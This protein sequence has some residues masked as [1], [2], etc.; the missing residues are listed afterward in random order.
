[1]AYTGLNTILKS[2]STSSIYMNSL[3]LKLFTSLVIFLV[4]ITVGK[5]AEMLLMKLFDEIELNKHLVKLSRLKWQFNI[6]MSKAIAYAIYI[7]SIVWA[8]NILGITRIIIFI[9]AGV[10]ALVLLLSVAFGLNDAI[11]NYFA[12]FIVRFRHNLKV[13]MHIRSGHLEGH[14]I[15]MDSQHV[16]LETGKAESVFIP[17]TA[18]LKNKVKITHQ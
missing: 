17:Y 15:N 10:L 4:G 18:L 2:F 3:L 6:I 1:M 11:A 13:G 8:L 16:R 12:G 9:I 5:I 7:I 14:I